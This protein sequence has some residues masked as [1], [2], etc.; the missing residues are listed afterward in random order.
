MYIRFYKNDGY[1]FKG[2]NGYGL[3][4]FS[5]GKNDAMRIVFFVA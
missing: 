5:N 3:I 4:D 1:K 2:N